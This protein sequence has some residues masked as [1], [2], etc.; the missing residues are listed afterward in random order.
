MNLPFI[1][2][3]KRNLVNWS[4]VEEVLGFTI[5]ENYKEFYETLGSIELDEFLYIVGLG[6]KG[7]I[8]DQVNDTVDAYEQ[9][10][11]YLDEPLE[12]VTKWL[13]VG[14]TI[15]ATYIFCNEEFVMLTDGGFDNKEVFKGSLLSF[16]EDIMANKVTS[17]HLVPDI[18]EIEHEIRI[19]DKQYL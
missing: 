1:L 15:D 13:P 3:L 11:E 4:K 10:K 14:Y 6:T 8:I 2:P 9:L 5:N 19:L 12:V 17:E 18:N 16:I 7:G